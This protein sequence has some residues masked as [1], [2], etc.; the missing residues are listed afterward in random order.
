MEKGKTKKRVKRA[1]CKK[2]LRQLFN[3]LTSS[4][5][6][7]ALQLNKTRIFC[8]TALLIIVTVQPASGMSPVILVGNNASDTAAQVEKACGLICKAT[9][10]ASKFVD[11]KEGRTAIIWLVWS[12]IA[13]GIQATSLMAAPTYGT[14]AIALAIFCSTAYGLETVIGSETFVGAEFFNQANT[15]CAKGY[16][17]LGAAAILPKDTINVAIKLLEG[18]K[19]LR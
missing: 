12:G 1:W 7:R 10:V 17:L 15:W 19:T 5:N 13:K 6:A 4:N 14:A 3:V 9:F 8:S 16:G 2:K 18:L 11:T